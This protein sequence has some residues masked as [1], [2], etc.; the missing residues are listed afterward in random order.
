MK[1]LNMVVWNFLVVVLS[2]P[3]VKW[4]LGFGWFAR[5][6]RGPMEMVERY[7]SFNVQ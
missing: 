5:S 1:L 3:K 4:V 6:F 7:H 2:E